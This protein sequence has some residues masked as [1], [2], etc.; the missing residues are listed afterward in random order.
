MKQTVQNESFFH[1]RRYRPWLVLLGVLLISSVQA[2]SMR[3]Q[4]TF[5]VSGI[6]KSEGGET[7]PGATILVKN[8]SQGTVSDVDGNFKIE[9][10]K[11]AILVI[12]FIG[13][14]TKEVPVNGRS[15]INI[16]LTS[17]TDVLDEVVVVGY[18]T[19]KKSLLTLVPR[20]H[21]QH[22][23]EEF[24]QVSCFQL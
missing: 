12:S 3:L 11:D 18:G 4:D 9:T 1:F 7:L 16:N 24:D 14:Q 22:G 5:P 17:D 23:R 21:H 2:R 8:S 15:V 6:V 13:F 19:Q 20:A 10:A